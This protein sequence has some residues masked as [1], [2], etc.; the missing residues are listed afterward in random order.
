MHPPSATGFWGPQHRHRK[1]RRR[2]QWL[3]VVWACQLGADQ[4]PVVG[5]VIVA[6][7]VVARVGVVAARARPRRSLCRRGPSMLTANGLEAGVGHG[8]GVQAPTQAAP[9]QH[10]HHVGHVT[11]RVVG[12]IE[13]RTTCE[14]KN[15]K[16][17]KSKKKIPPMSFPVTGRNVNIIE[18][19]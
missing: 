2:R 8:I 9:D 5:I 19:G 10:G 18:R 6:A 1:R 16:I 13:V 12:G 15:P 7:I 14:E 17:Q 4:Q 3:L 11:R